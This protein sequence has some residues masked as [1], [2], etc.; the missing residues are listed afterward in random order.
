MAIIP[1]RPLFTSALPPLWLAICLLSFRHPG[2]EYG[3]FGF[4]SLAGLWIFWIVGDSGSPQQLLI[5]V[6]VTGTLTMLAL[7]WLLDRLRAPLL[8]WLVIWLAAAFLLTGWVLWQFPTW[9]RAISKNGSL[10][11]YVLFGTNLGL[12]LATV[13]MVLATASVQMAR[14]LGLRRPPA[15]QRRQ[16]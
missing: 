8:V 10:A 15:S 3:L 4:G 14:Q 5:Y 11:A 9:E 2:D 12:T 13:V 16:V 7:G 6:A 1:A